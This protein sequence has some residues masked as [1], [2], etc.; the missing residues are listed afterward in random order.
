MF[1]NSTIIS[2]LTIFSLFKPSPLLS[3]P[4]AR[5]RPSIKLVDSNFHRFFNSALKASFANILTI[6]RN[7]FL[8]LLNS[9][10]S[11]ESCSNF[12]DTSFPNSHRTFGSSCVYISGCTF[13]NCASSY[14][15]AILANTTTL[16]IAIDRSNFTS[17]TATN[18]GGALY[19]C[20]TQ[21]VPTS[22]ECFRITYCI[23][24]YCSCYNADP[25]IMLYGG[26]IY[27]R[28]HSGIFRSSQFAHSYLNRGYGAGI[29][30]NVIDASNKFFFTSFNNCTID[31]TITDSTQSRGGA[32]Y[33]SLI[34]QG[35]VNI[36]YIQ[37]NSCS[38]VNGSCF[39]LEN[40]LSV[41]LNYTDFSLVQ[42][43]YFD[44][45]ASPSAQMTLGVLVFRSFPSTSTAE[46]TIVSSD[47][48]LTYTNS[49]SN[50]GTTYQ[51]QTPV[52]IFEPLSSQD[53]SSYL[54]PDYVSNYVGY[55]FVVPANA[56]N[57]PDTE[58]ANSLTP[59]PTTS[60]AVPTPTIDAAV[61]TASLNP[62]PT[63]TPAATPLATAT[64]AP[65]Q[66]PAPTATLPAATPSASAPPLGTTSIVLIVIACIIV[67]VAIIVTIILIVRRGGCSLRIPR[68]S[69]HNYVPQKSRSLGTYF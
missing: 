61:P 22:V 3:I 19:L 69:I 6:K 38:A 65:T 63:A 45:T 67:A 17:C 58:I 30:I 64:P 5:S 36:S 13:T 10:V 54:N 35:N 2:G 46:Y 23:F 24:N 50:K 48:A 33:I 57:D 49:I 56:T 29:Y 41:T 31:S 32:G 53:V 28:A 62:L 51:D 18:A 14:G 59:T 8:Y 27:L 15:G 1:L 20:D 21:E 39:F 52:L 68:D 42:D 4:G 47:Q 9:A 34:N 40:V 55:P 43:R 26:A 16:E 66:T 44:L 25:T 11:F 12:I 7:N 60:V 37:F